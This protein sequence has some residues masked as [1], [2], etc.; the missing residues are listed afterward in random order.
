M[1][2]KLLKVTDVTRLPG[3][4]HSKAWRIR[5]DHPPRR[6]V[7]YS[8]INRGK[9]T[10]SRQSRIQQVKKKKRMDD[11]KTE[12]DSSN[13]SSSSDD[14]TPAKRKNTKPNQ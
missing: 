14:E 1:Q 12:T 10:L 11:D 4:D 13:S 2:R 5:N 3:F 8:D 6:K 7:D 9:H